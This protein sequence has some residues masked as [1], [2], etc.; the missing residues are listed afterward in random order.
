M[1]TLKLRQLAAG[2]AMAG[3][4]LVSFSAS[5]VGSVPSFKDAPKLEGDREFCLDKSNG[6]YEHPDCRVHYQCSRGLAAEVKCPEGQVFDASK[7]PDDDPA[8]SACVV[9]EQA[10]HVDCS[11]LALHK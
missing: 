5:A 4:V 7:N 1:K 11:G 2:A 10:S 6:S 8:Q 9:P 3:A